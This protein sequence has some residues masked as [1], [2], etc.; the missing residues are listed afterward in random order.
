MARKSFS[1]LLDNVEGQRVLSPDEGRELLAGCETGALLLEGLWQLAQGALD[2]G[3]EA[4]RLTFLLKEFLDVIAVGR[5]VFGAASQRVRQADL[6]PEGRAEGESLLGRLDRR[7]AE[8]HDRL[9][10]LVRW[11]ET[12]PAPINAAALPAGRGEQRAEGYL[13]HE[14]MTA[15]LLS[16]DGA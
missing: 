10:A 11:L 2:R 12:P 13:G 9:S 15:R 7:A 14:E 6:A 8:M 1:V 16:S 5:K 4:R 3:M